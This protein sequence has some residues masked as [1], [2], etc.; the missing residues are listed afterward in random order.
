M[1][2]FERF[3]KHMISPK[4]SPNL[5]RDVRLF[6][7]E[8]LEFRLYTESSFGRCL[9][10]WLPTGQSIQ[11]PGFQ[12][13]TDLKWIFQ[14]SMF[15]SELTKTNNVCSNL[16]S[17][18]SLSL[19]SSYT[20]TYHIQC[21]YMNINIQYSNLYRYIYTPCNDNYLSLHI[22]FTT[23]KL[24]E[25]TPLKVKCPWPA[26]PLASPRPS[27][28]CHATTG[29]GLGNPA[30]NPFIKSTITWQHE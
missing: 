8:L 21:R 14:P 20:Q 28:R 11:A 13:G 25:A 15:G 24:F 26:A 22:I 23:E 17:I 4:F 30:W 12:G 1:D 10:V 7:M 16:G 29:Q 27:S 6:E 19:P 9:V 18:P 5:W 3:K 2:V